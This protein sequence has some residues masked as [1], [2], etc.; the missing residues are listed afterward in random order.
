MTTGIIVVF[1]KLEDGKK[2]KN[3]LVRYGFEVVALCQSGASAIQMVDHMESG[4]VICGYRLSDMIYGDLHDDLPK[5]FEMI[6]MATDQR[7][8]EGIKEG[9][10]SVSMPVKIVDLIETVEMVSSNIIRQ[11]KKEKSKPGKRTEEEKKIIEKAK[12]ILMERN[13]LSEKEAHKYLQKTS[14]DSGTSIVETAMMILSL[15]DSI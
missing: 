5:H 8:S 15:M 4:I 3:I 12:H 10:I 14:M 1:P 6:L 7:L 11:I 9:V 2:I 13:K